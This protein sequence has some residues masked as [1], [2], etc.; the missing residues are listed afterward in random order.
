MTAD[1]AFAVTLRPVAEALRDRAA[2]EARQV[3]AAA[4]E[5]ADRMVADARAEAARTLTEARQRGTADAESAM[6]HEAIRA[7]RQARGLVLRTRQQAY[8]QLRTRCRQAVLELRHEPGYPQL[9]EQLA[10]TARRVL[11]P[12]AVV[13]D[14]PEGGVIG[15]V[16]GRRLDL[17]LLGFADRAL[18]AMGGWWEVD[19]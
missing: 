15:E 4:D 2:A 16:A 19:P 12:G 18:A 10:D 8:E 7:R 11:G 17:S 13:R 14:A 3:R 1:P 5:A 9:R 6:A